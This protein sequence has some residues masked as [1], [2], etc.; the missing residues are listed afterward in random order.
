MPATSVSDVGAGHAR[1]P[2]PS[3]LNMAALRIE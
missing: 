1:D 3:G 2:Q